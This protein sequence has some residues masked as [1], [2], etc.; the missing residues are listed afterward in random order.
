MINIFPK[1]TKRLPKEAMIANLAGF[2][3]IN[4]KASYAAVQKFLPVKAIWI[5]AFLFKNSMNLWKQA[6]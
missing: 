4:Q 3:A 1:T 2:L 6:M 5:Y